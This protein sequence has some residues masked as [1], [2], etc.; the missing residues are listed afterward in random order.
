M[1]RREDM[2]SLDP[3]GTAML[4]FDAKRHTDTNSLAPHRVF[5]TPDYGAAGTLT[6]PRGCLALVNGQSCDPL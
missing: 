1:D 5:V 4:C 3:H 6:P 2:G